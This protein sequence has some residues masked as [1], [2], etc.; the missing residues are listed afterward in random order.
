MNQV[1]VA[2]FTLYGNDDVEDR[3]QEFFGILSTSMLHLGEQ[4]KRQSRAKEIPN[5]ESVYILI[6]LIVQ[7]SQYLTT[8]IFERCFPYE[9]LRNS[10]HVVHKKENEANEAIEQ[11]ERKVNKAFEV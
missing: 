1:L 3:I 9:L 8:D 5:L 2:L 6:D 11:R 10:Y 7:K 4:G